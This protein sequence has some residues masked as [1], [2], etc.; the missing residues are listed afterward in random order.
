MSTP[1]PNAPTTPAGPTPPVIPVPTTPLGA[2]Q[3]MMSL[4]SPP[5]PSQGAPSSHP[6]SALPVEISPEA[7]VRAFS[8]PAHAPPAHVPAHATQIP[9]DI[10]LPAA[11]SVSSHGGRNTPPRTARVMRSYPA[12]PELGLPPPR[13]IP[14]PG[15]D[16]FCRSTAHYE[17]SETVE[18]TQD[19]KE[20]KS[21]VRSSITTYVSSWPADPPPLI[22]SSQ[23]RLAHDWIRRLRKPRESATKL[24]RQV[25]TFT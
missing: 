23:V 13:P 10:T 9:A 4:L 24:R 18:Q 20:K 17:H 14:V 22:S 7:L 3:T 15:G 8:P 11:A 1:Q 16:G 12:L 25:T 19:D 5:A 21:P 6:T 2:V